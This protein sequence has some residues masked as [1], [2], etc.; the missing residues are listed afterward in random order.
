M[1]Q[2]L[3][4]GFCDR[5]VGDLVEHEALH[6][7]DAPVVYEV[8]LDEGNEYATLCSRH[9]DIVADELAANGHNVTD[10]LVPERA[11]KA[12][13]PCSRCETGCYI[14][15]CVSEPRAAVWWDKDLRVRVC[16]GHADWSDP[17]RYELLQ[18]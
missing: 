3:E 16:S 14:E 17:G 13:E 18:S 2:E 11:A 4:C 6:L 10:Y 5:L 8:V 12:D 15:G 9:Y 7:T 1:M